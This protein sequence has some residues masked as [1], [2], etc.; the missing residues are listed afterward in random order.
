MCH[1]RLACARDLTY[2]HRTHTYKTTQHRRTQRDGRMH[3][4]GAF[5]QRFPIYYGHRRACIAETIC[6]NTGQ[7]RRLRRWR[8]GPSIYAKFCSVLSSRLLPTSSTLSSLTITAEHIAPLYG[9]RTCLRFGARVRVLS[10]VPCYASVLACRD[11][12][13]QTQ[14]RNSSFTVAD[15]LINVVSP[16]SVIVA[17]K[18]PS[19]HYANV[20]AVCIEVRDGG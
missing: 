2:T 5:A 17:A 6:R 12:I 18:S 15:I 8:A 4:F 16:T 10:S 14:T 1:S 3:A 20:S 13:T 19:R 11:R 7:R 9:M